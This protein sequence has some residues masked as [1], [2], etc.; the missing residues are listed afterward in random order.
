MTNVIKLVVDKQNELYDYLQSYLDYVGK[1]SINTRKTYASQINV[2]FKE[3]RSKK[4]D[5]LT[6]QDF[7]FTFKEMTDYFVKIQKE[8]KS[9]TV[10]TRY[11]A[12]KGYFEYLKK[13]KFTIDMDLFDL[14]INNN[15]YDS[16]MYEVL[17]FDE[18][19]TLACAVRNQNNGL[20]KYL[21]IQLAIV[22]SFRLASLLTLKWGDF[23]KTDSGVNYIRV[24][25]K[26]NIWD[27]KSIRQDLY[28]SLMEYKKTLGDNE[29][30]FP[31]MKNGVNVKRMIDSAL[32]ELGWSSRNITFHSFKKAGIEAVKVITNG[33]IKAMQRQGNHRDVNTTLTNYQKDKSELDSMPSLLIGAEVD[34]SLI[35]NA[36]QEELVKA[37][38]QGGFK[39]KMQILNI[40]KNQ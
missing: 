12:V 4:V 21:F 37:I 39:L 10:A 22:T 35:E 7:Q 30:V 6:I 38:E 9:K 18:A 32:V 33:D 27:E 8:L 24:L 29:L 19:M 31:H 2:F 3:T 26:G 23:K 40:L 11:N 20:E 5:A 1:D 28:D 15:H 16:E 14:D 25:G 34:F 13:N 17:D 36:T